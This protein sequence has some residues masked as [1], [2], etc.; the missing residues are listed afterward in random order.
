MPSITFT[1]REPVVPVPFGWSPTEQH[2]D[3]G[4]AMDDPLI[5]IKQTGSTPRTIICTL[6]H[7][8]G[9][10]YFEVYIGTTGAA[11]T[12]SAVGIRRDEDSGA[13]DYSTNLGVTSTQVGRRSEGDDY[14]SNFMFNAFPPAW[15]TASTFYT[16]GVAVHFGTGLWISNNGTYWSFFGNSPDPETNTDPLLIFGQTVPWYPA[17]AMQSNLITTAKLNATASNI[18]NLPAGFTPWAD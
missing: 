11:G 4:G 3:F 2:S 13:G 14:I 18:I 16:I 10:R 12:G 9:K 8:S 7:D 17:V 5:A 1:V 6:P 15:N